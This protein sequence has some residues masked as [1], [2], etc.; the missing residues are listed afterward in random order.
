MGSPFSASIPITAVR[1]PT[2]IVSSNVIG[3]NIGQLCI[4]RPPTLSG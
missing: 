1:P 4:G 2:R 3:T